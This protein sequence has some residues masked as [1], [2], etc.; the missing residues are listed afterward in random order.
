MYKRQG[1]IW[2]GVHDYRMDPNTTAKLLQFISEPEEKLENM[3]IEEYFGKDS[4]FFDS[5]MW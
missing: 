2:E 5:A 1:H 3:T 4:P